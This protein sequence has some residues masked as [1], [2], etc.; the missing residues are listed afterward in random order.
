MDAAPLVFAPCC[1]MLWCFP[2]L[3]VQ[4]PSGRQWEHGVATL[5]VITHEVLTVQNLTDITAET[6]GELWRLLA[7]SLPSL[8]MT[9][10]WG[11]AH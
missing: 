4:A 2:R 10:S 7:N 3:V 1:G 9:I 6:E 11:S 8:P 5:K